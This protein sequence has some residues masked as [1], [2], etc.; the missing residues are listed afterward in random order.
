MS[1]IN[2]PTKS[3]KKKIIK[4]TKTK[5]N[6]DK[7]KCKDLYKPFE[8]RVEEEFKKNDMDLSSINYNLEEQILKQLETVVSPSDIKPTDDFYT[9]INDRWLIDKEEE[10]KNLIQFD[11]FRIV[12]SNINKELIEIFRDYCEKNNTSEAQNMN[13]LLKSVS[14]FTTNIESI[15]NCT[16]FLT[17]YAEFAK[18][19]E[20]YFKF[21]AYLNKNPT[22]SWSA[23]LVWT[24]QTNDNNPE[25]LISGFSTPKFTLLNYEMYFPEI[26]KKN[27]SYQKFLDHYLE[28]LEKLFVNVFGENH[29]FDVTEV[30]KCECDMMAQFGCNKY[31]NKEYNI[32]KRE[33]LSVYSFNYKDFLSELGFEKYPEEFVVN[34]IN[35]FACINKLLKDNWTD[36]KW[37]TYFLYMF[38]RNEQRFNVT[39]YQIT[40]D[41][42]YK[43]LKGGLK[44]PDKLLGSVYVLTY[45]YHNFLNNKY[46]EKANNPLIIEYTNSLVT[47]LREVYIRIIR[48]NKWLQIETKLKALDKLNNYKFNIGS[49]IID[50]TDPFVEFK[51]A[52]PYKNIEKMGNRLVKRLISRVGTKLSLPPTL[53]W[54]QFPPKYIGNSSFIVNAFYTPN[55]NTIDVPLGYLQFPFVDLKQR[56]IEYNLA[57]IG[58]TVAHEMSHALDNTGSKYDKDGK[59]LNW[60]L[61][62]DAAHFKKLQDDVIKQYEKFASYDDFTFDASLSIGENMADISA[63]AICMEYLR[64]FQL[65]NK[66]ILP[67]QS[68]SFKT[69]FIYYAYHQRQ[70]VNSKAIKAQMISNPHPLEKY[71][72]NVPLSRLEVFRKLYR[73]SKK[74]KMW[75]ND[76]NK[77]WS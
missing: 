3:T 77:I 35:Y 69:F 41:F 15:S 54:S 20:N 64:D 51:D 24:V 68:I 70:I 28:Y 37:K 11:N 33:D 67:I 23:P 10:S 58:F 56:G 19:K 59:R 22:I 45:C 73:I 30:Y 13:R 38:L 2:K 27:K 36:K 7:Y 75:W 1:E 18:K 60:W 57:H 25:Y 65:L 63:V 26:V 21:L 39:G 17:Q 29:G 47:D 62:K 5:K 71:R 50:E 34:D 61:K 66:Y 16:E 46:I 76:S 31:K 53:D 72:T 48:R 49:K 74:D 42:Q 8:K 52:N 9:Y 43:Y 4:Q 14:N 55:K 12:Q 44:N 6:Y 40:Y 32:L